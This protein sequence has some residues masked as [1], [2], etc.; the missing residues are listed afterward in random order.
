MKDIKFAIIQLL[1][2]FYTSMAF[3]SDIENKKANGHVLLPQ[4]TG[5]YIFTNK[6]FTQLK[7]SQ[8]SKVEGSVSFTVRLY[9]EPK[10]LDNIPSF[11]LGDIVQRGKE[12]HC[13]IYKLK[14]KRDKMLSAYFIDSKV[15]LYSKY[16][17][18]D[19]EILS[20]T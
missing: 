19:K 15:G 3:A 10:V 6:D 13:F 8:P 11:E 9:F 18:D 20:Q 16:I 1:I 17:F 4:K 12:G 5:Y 2:I 14:L 7:P